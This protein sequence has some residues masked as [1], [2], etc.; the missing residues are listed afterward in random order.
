MYLNT[1]VLHVCIHSNMSQTMT[2]AGFAMLDDKNI[3]RLFTHIGV[4]SCCRKFL[5]YYSTKQFRN[6]SAIVSYKLSYRVCLVSE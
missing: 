5:E 4:K 3:N 1:Y 2:A 6:M